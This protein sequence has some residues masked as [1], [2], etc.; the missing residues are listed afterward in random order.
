MKPLLDQTSTL[1][2]MDGDMELLST[3]YSLYL[4]DIPPKL[5]KI[6][7]ALQENDA[8]T[9]KDLAHSIKGGSSTIGAEAMQE[10]ARALETLAQD[11]RSSEDLTLGVKE[12]QRLAEATFIALD[13]ALQSRQD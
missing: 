1:Q 6:A 7:K 4:Q 5:E 2:R 9:I 3:L 13:H 12:L 11:N 10:Q 8:Q